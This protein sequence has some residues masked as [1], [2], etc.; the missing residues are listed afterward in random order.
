VEPLEIAKTLQARFPDEVRE[1][2]EFGGQ[3][4]VILRMDRITDVVTYLK[5]DSALQM[6]LLKDLC[7]VDYHEKK[8]PRFEVV[9][10]L[11]SVKFRYLIRLRAEVPEEDP[12]IESVVRVHRGADWHERECYDLFGITF[13]G[14]PDLRRILMPDDWE[15]HPLRK[16]YPYSGPTGENEWKRFSNL[17]EKAEENKKFEWVRSRDQL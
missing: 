10:H 11:Y 14:H 5:T 9:Y 2:K 13:K 1:V 7:G 4:A 6:D 16:D 15:G 12:V 8:K 3:V 17:L